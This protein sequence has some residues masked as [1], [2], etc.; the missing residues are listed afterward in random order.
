MLLRPQV[1]GQAHFTRQVFEAGQL[2]SG[3]ANNGAL[4]LQLWSKQVYTI[5]TYVGMHLFFSVRSK[6]AT[7]HILRPI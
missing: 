3:T 5:H 2:D 6:T 4:A 7:Q 1:A